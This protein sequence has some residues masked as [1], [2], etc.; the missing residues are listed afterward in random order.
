[1]EFSNFLNKD[2]KILN[3]NKKNQIPLNTNLD[4]NQ[5]K[6]LV[7]AE[8]QENENK[9]WQAEKNKYF[10]DIQQGDQF[11]F[12]DLSIIFD[13]DRLS[14]IFPNNSMTYNEKLNSI[15]RMCILI[16][17]VLMIIRKNYLYFYIIIFAGFFTYLLNIYN[18]NSKKENIENLYTQNNNNNN[19]NSQ[20]DNTTICNIPTHN[21]PFMN[22]L[23]SDIK[24][25]PKHK[26]C[27]PN[28]EIKSKINKYFNYN[29]YSDVGDVFNNRNSQRQYYTNPSTTLP[30]DQGRFA[31]WLYKVPTSCKSGDGIACAGLQSPNMGPSNLLWRYTP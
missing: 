4:N 28:N 26:A 23:I 27:P 19:D 22:L 8:K 15:F 21:N 2:K 31:N 18:F 11:W 3:K 30:N 24:Y 5:I 20:N 29:L 25:N 13:V 17:I 14:E 9:N 10:S 1:M 16:S 7:E 6:F 12:N